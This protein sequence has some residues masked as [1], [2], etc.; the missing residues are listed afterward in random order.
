MKGNTLTF[1]WNV[2]KDDKKH[3]ENNWGFRCT[4]YGYVPNVRRP[5]QASSC[6]KD[7][8]KGTLNASVEGKSSAQK[9]LTSAQANTGK[10]CS[11]SND[12]D[13]NYDDVQDSLL[14]W[15]NYPSSPTNTFCK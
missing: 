4:V 10:Y 14:P 13:E 8:N 12:G 3:K 5:R 7:V 1:F 15:G 9:N 6:A 11:K 2:E